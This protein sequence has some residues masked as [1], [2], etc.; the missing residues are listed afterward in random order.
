[1]SAQVRTIGELL[2]QVARRAD[3]KI[4]SGLRHDEDTVIA[5]L[6]RSIRRWKQMIAE[7]GDDADMVTTRVVTIPDATR[8]A[9]N[10]AP[11]MYLPQPQP[12]SAPMWR[13]RSMDIWPTSKRFISM[14]PA[15]EGGRDFAFDGW[16]AK[17]GTGLPVFYRLGGQVVGAPIIQIFPWADAAYPVDIRYIPVWVDKTDLGD[18]VECLIGGDEWIV[19]DVAIQALLSDG[20]GAQGTMQQLVAWNQ[21]IARDMQFAFARRSPVRKLDTRTERRLLAGLASPWWRGLL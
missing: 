7:A 1:M 8:G 6:N 20:Q 5:D 18:T 2:A 11:N 10:W 21:Q 19:N 4:A 14:M 9:D 17:P 13:V 12:P 3:I 15:D 16:L